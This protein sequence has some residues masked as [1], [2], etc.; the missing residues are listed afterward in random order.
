M[1]SCRLFLGDNFIVPPCLPALNINIS[2]NINKH[3]LRTSKNERTP[4]SQKISLSHFI[5]ERVD[6]SVVCERWAE[7]RRDCYID[8]TSSPH[9]SMLC[10]LQEPTWHF[11]RILVGVAQPGVTEGNSH[12]GA[13]SVRKLILTLAFLSPT[14]S[15]AAG[16]YLYFFITSS[17]F[18]FFCLFTQEH[19]RLT[20]RSRVR[21]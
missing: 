4:F 10:Y 2:G 13:F 9:Y 6:D 20:A 14:D 5:L 17:C 7:T 18:R 11:F 15:T 3:N 12:Q 19:L 16:L 8:P 21:I 1:E